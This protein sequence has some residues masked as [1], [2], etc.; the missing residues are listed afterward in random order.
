MGDYCAAIPDFSAVIPAKAGI[1]MI[2]AK[3]AIRNQ[4]PRPASGSPLP[5]WERARVRVTRASA[6]LRAGR[7]RSQ[8]RPLLA[9]YERRLG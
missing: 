3:F 1:Q 2:A 9:I 4:A 8:A 6:V 7:P 5:L